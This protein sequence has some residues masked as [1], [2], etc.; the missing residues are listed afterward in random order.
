MLLPDTSVGFF[1]IILSV[2]SM[3]L[4]RVELHKTQNHLCELNSVLCVV[5]MSPKD[6]ENINS[7]SFFAKV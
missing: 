1:F 6:P 5:S 2:L 4:A 3:D 7:F